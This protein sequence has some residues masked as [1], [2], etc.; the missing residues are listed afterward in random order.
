M[1]VDYNA[2]REENL[3][4]YGRAIGRDNG[5][6]QMLLA[7]RYDDRTHFIFEVV[8]NAE[9]ALKKRGEWSGKRSVA[10]S[11]SDAAL[12][13]SHYGKP[14][15][16]ADVRGVC[17]I[18][19]STKEWTDIGRFGIGFK[20]VYALTESP[21]IHS[22]EEG[23]AIDKYVLPK[24]IKKIGLAPE[25]TLIRLPF[26]EN[27][28]TDKDAV[29]KGLQRI[30]PRTLLFLREIE[31]IAWSVDGEPAGNYRR[32][33]A[34]SL[35]DFARKVQIVGPNNAETEVTGEWL[36]F[37]REVFHEEES[38]GYV[39]IAFELDSGSEN[40]QNPRVKKLYDSPLVVFFPTVISTGLGFLV[41]GPYRT[42][43]SRDNIP[44]A[45]PWNCHL[46]DETAALL[47]DALKGLRKLGL[48]DVAALRSLPLLESARF[49]PLFRAVKES[50]LKEAMLPGHR[51]KYIAGQNAKL[52]GSRELRELITDKQ[53]AALFPDESKPAWLSGDITPNLTPD[54]YR[55]LT[56]ELGIAEINPDGLIRR[57]NR[58]FLEAQSDK[59]VG[60]L[61]EFLNGQRARNIQ[62][63]LPNIP[64]VRLEDG[65]HTR[66][67][68]DGKPQ[69]YLPGD[70]RTGFPTVRRSV[71]RT[72]EARGFLRSIRLRNPDL[73]DDV[74]ENLLPKYRAEVVD[75]PDQEYE[76]DISW[77]LAAFG[78]DSQEQRRNLVSNLQEAKFVAAVD[79][80]TG[81]FRLVKP[82]E[83][84]RTERLKALFQGVP[85]VLVVDDVSRDYLQGD[86][87]RDLLR[88]VGTPEYLIRVPVVTSFTD[89]ERRKAVARLAR[90]GRTPEVKDYTLMGLDALLTTL[91]K[92]PK[93][94]AV[95]RANL[96][97]RA[98]CD[99]QQQR[100]SSQFRGG[101]SW[102]YYTPKSGEFLASSVKT[103]KQTSWV[104]DGMGELQPPSYVVFKDTGW[105]ENPFLNGIIQFKA[106]VIEE[107]A[108]EA[109][110]D[111]GALDFLKKHD[112]SEA[113]LREA[114][115]IKEDND[116]ISTATPSDEPVTHP[117]SAPTADPGIVSVPRPTATTGAGQNQTNAQTG[118]GAVSRP[119]G[120]RE[121]VTYVKVVSDE[122]DADPD[123][124]T[125]QSRMSLEEKAIAFILSKEPSLQRTRAGNPGFDLWEAGPGGQP[126]RWV[127]VKAMSGNFENRPATLTKTQ[128][129]FAQAR[130]DAFSLYVVENAGDPAQSRIVK[131]QNPAGK[132]Q[133][134]TFD[135][136]WVNLAEK[137]D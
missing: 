78:T 122:S 135:R 102:F 39:E 24:A 103:L 1:P 74:I 63:L 75:I 117:S 9:D 47:A 85:G 14:F 10:F 46:V 4:E 53:L 20:S 134:F 109:G 73:V 7:E 118:S 99:T 133:T 137:S 34:E 130:Q 65:S 25:E 29:L 42:T 112:I 97:W 35:L 26:G 38:A 132:A 88:A 86:Q 116:L 123:G 54:L 91:A 114:F 124:L 50:L 40:R 6:W 80:G 12:T 66:A 3:A 100:G 83:A 79:A 113:K 115:G 69:A 41:Q 23:F 52:A 108:K 43:P 127:E 57:L 36:V 68:V 8:Q 58:E 51:R 19:A 45:E 89:E 106:A 30:G 98:L 128:F 101:Y 87:P 67:V 84:Y 107:L 55:Y 15:D 110:I 96:L 44:L 105:E 32:L 28:G 56:G 62:Q 77:I 48:L 131:I 13:I 72:E 104:P 90:I 31:E 76:S 95:A 33:S 81:A 21:E 71:C 111:P 59:W 16:E 5:P 70:N 18:G 136:G 125:H 126:A 61:Y 60:R 129:E 64:L 37:S 119:T 27:K 93:D 17:G 121:F 2:L 92:L 22:G 49:D 82:G 94:Q 11:L 120:H